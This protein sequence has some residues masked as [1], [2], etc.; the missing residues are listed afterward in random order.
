MARLYIDGDE[1]RITKRDFCCVDVEF[2]SG[3]KLEKLEP[4][5]LFP[6]SG[7]TKYITLLDENGKEQAIIRNVDVLMPDSKNVIKECLQEYYLVPK[8]LKLI[9]INEKLGMLKW[10]VET[11]RGTHTFE[12]RNRHS[13]IKMLYDGRVLVKDSNDNRYEITDYKSL[14]KHSLSLLSSEL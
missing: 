11:D 6:V 2:Y 13:D 14:D 5:R 4:R 3:Q 12:I 8:I 10:T 1:V 7:L 9:D